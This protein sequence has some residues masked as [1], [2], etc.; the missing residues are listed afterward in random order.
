[1]TNMPVHLMNSEQIGFTDDQKVPITKFDFRW[2]NLGIFQI[3]ESAFSKNIQYSDA[4]VTYRDPN[5]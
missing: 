1:M 4:G 3:Q 5:L 2:G